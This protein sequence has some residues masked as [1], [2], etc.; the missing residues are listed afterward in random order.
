MGLANSEHST[1]LS[2]QDGK[3]V[4]SIK[5]H[6]MH[7]DSIEGI[8]TAM[9]VRETDYGKQWVVS[10]VDENESFK[11]IIPYSGGYA[12]CLLKTIPNINIAMPVKLTPQL[13]IENDKKKA[14]L[15][16]N[17]GGNPLKWA[18]TMKEPGA[19]PPLEKVVFQGKERWDDT[20]QMVFLEA[21]VKQKLAGIKPSALLKPSSTKNE[22]IEDVGQASFIEDQPDD[23]L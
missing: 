5:E 16:I 9:E 18:F 23:F 22:K 17:Q 4:K 8:I 10:M 14:S 6:E 1:F 19:C 12:N 15:F 11:V 21:L 7:Y 3:V 2:I 20:K 13:K